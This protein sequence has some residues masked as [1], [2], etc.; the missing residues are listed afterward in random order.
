MN[1]WSAWNLDVY[2]WS[3]LVWLGAFIVLETLAIIEDRHNTL[4]EHLRPVLTEHPLAWFLTLGL[5]LWLGVHF[6]APR[7][8]WALLDR[9]VR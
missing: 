9:F 4:T 7:M 2:T 1:R 3:W 5:W 8:E 6:L